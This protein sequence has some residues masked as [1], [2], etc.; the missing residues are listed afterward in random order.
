MKIGSLS[1]HVRVVKVAHTTADYFWAQR[2]PYGETAIGQLSPVSFLA[3]AE[4]TKM[5]DLLYLCLFGI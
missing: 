3:R 5:N 2:S 1:M 4:L